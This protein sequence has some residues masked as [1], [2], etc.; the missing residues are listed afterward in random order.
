MGSYLLFSGYRVSTQDFWKKDE[1]HLCEY[2]FSKRFILF[3]EREIRASFR[4]AQC[5]GST[6]WP[7]QDCKTDVL[8]YELF[9]S[10][11]ECFFKKDLLCL[12]GERET[13][14]PPCCATCSATVEPSPSHTHVVPSGT[15]LPSQLP[16]HS[17][18]ALT[19]CV[20][21]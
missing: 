1:S 6:D 19:A 4:F 21:S 12:L 18:C 13:R 14:P 5:Q 8:S 7:P 17:Y 11:S 3:I 15:D 16:E 10:H 20:K 2:S 9:P